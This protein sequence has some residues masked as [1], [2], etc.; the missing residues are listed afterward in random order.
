MS[1]LEMPTFET[2][3]IAALAAYH[4]LGYH[5]EPNCWTDAEL[6]ELQQASKTF[7]SYQDRTFSPVMRAH[8][9]NPVFARALRNRK[10]VGIM[11]RL[12]SGPVSAIQSE[13]FYCPPGTKGFSM[14]QDNSYVQAKPD[15]FGSAWCALQDVGPDNGGLIVFP[16]THRED[17]LPVEACPT[18]CRQDCQD[19]N[20]NAI[21][22]VLPSKY[23]GVDAR[24]PK[25]GVVY[26]HAHVVHSSRDNASDGFRRALL[27]TYIRRG[28]TFRPGNHAKRAEVNVYD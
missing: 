26:L 21:Q 10:I 3:P 4:E 22:V 16:G 6:H 19:P 18:H 24:V 17:I 25:G 28:E 27:M 9:A 12:L 8:L 14:H 5:I 11:E 20:A 13:L 23:Q 15:A 2:D 1:Q 7:L